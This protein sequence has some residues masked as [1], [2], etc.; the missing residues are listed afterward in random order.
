MLHNTRKEVGEVFVCFLFFCGYK[1]IKSISQR[2]CHSTTDS[3][4]ATLM[5]IMLQICDKPMLKAA[6]GNIKTRRSK[7]LAECHAGCALF[8][9]V[10]LWVFIVE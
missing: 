4:L 7:C 8:F 3:R 5:R 1:G 9:F 2:F 6:N 10:C